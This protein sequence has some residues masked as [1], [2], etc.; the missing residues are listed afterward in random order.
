M[1]TSP[2]HI[3]VGSAAKA[4]MGALYSAPSIAAVLPGFVTSTVIA[5]ESTTLKGTDKMTA[6]LNATSAFV[7]KEAPLVGAQMEAFMAAVEAFAEA[8]VALYNDIGVFVHK[9]QDTVAGKA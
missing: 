4:I 5:V 1:T 7:A 2:L 9:V 6:V 3:S 8:L